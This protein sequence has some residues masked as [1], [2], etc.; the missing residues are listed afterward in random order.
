MEIVGIE[1]NGVH[2]L[3]YRGKDNSSGYF[4]S[5]MCYCI[6]NYFD[7]IIMNESLNKWFSLIPNDPVFGKDLNYNNLIEEHYGMF[8]SIHLNTATKKKRIEDIAKKL[9]IEVFV[10]TLE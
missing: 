7:R 1:I 6:R 9:R 5:F 10:H 3:P 4:R 8:F 2:F